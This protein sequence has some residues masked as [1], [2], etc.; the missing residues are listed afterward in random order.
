MTLH[1]PSALA[2]ARHIE[3]INGITYPQGIKS[4]ELELNVNVHKGKFRYHL[5]KFMP[6]WGRSSTRFFHRYDRDFLLQFMEIC[7]EKPDNLP[8]LGD[9]GLEPRWMPPPQRA[10][11]SDRR[12]RVRSKRGKNKEPRAVAPLAVSFGSASGNRWVATS[13]S[14]PGARGNGNSDNSGVDGDG[15]TERPDLVDR[16]VRALLNKLTADRFDS[17]S[18]QVVARANRSAERDS[19][20][21]GRTLIRVTELVFES[22]TNGTMFPE[23]Y[24]RLCRKMMERIGPHAQDHGIKDAKGNPLAGGQLFRK[25]LLNCCREAFEGWITKP[26]ASAATE[27]RVVKGT[28]EEARG[29]GSEPCSDEYYVMAKAKRHRLG[30]VCFVG[31]LFM[32]QILTER[33]VHEYIKKLLGKEKTGEVEIEGLCRLLKSVGGRLDSQKA[34]AH[35]DVY[36]SRMRELAEDR[37]ATTLR[38]AC[39]LQVSVATPPCVF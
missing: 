23:L 38:M 4:P 34:R 22:A 39:M 10:S 28:D 26:A 18:D 12:T 8:P 27:D 7:R 16:K 6:S 11:G 25:Y 1:L 14:D 17:I 36:F 13:L 33:I 32:S 21:D 19:E 2:T 9:L 30:L 31:E 20:N 35:V 37:G 15:V 3:D 29:S 5:S 24:A